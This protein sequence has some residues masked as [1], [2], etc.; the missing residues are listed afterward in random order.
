MSKLKIILTVLLLIA[1]VV[2]P[3]TYGMGLTA[4]ESGQ[5]PQ[6]NLQAGLLSGS[7]TINETD[8][9]PREVLF[10]YHRQTNLQLTPANFQ[11]SPDGRWISWNAPLNG[12]LQ[13]WVAPA[14]DLDRARAVTNDTGQGIGIG[15]HFW[16]Y[17][18][19]TLIYEQDTDGD[20][21]FRWY[22]VDA[23]RAER[24]SL[25]PQKGVRAWLLGMSFDV[26]GE[27]LLG[28]NDRDPRFSDVYRVNISTGERLLVLKNEGFSD[29]TTDN[30]LHIRLAGNTSVDGGTEYYSL[31]NGAWKLFMKVKPEDAMTFP[32]A[33]NRAGDILYLLDSRDRNTAAFA[34]INMTTGEET[35]LS[36]NPK[37]DVEISILHPIDMTP[38]AVSYNYERTHWVALNSSISKDLEYLGTLENGDLEFQCATVDDSKWLVGYNRDTGPRRYYL[39]DRKD[40]KARYLHTDQPELENYTLARMHPIVVKSRDGLDLVCY[41]TL[42]PW[43]D[44]DDDGMPEKPLPMVLLVHGGPWGRDVWGFDAERQFLANR[45]Y[46]VLNVNFRGSGGFGKSFLNAGDREWGGKMQA[47]LLDAVNWTVEKGISDP[48]RIAIM[49]GSYGGYATL[50]GLAMT[51]DF[52]ACGV[53]CYGISNL[54]SHLLTLPPH[55]QSDSEKQIR[56]VG[57][58]RTEEGRQ[59]LRERSPLTYADRIKKPLLI[60]HGAND[61]Q[62]NKNQSDQIVQI[63]VDKGIPIT[64]ALY[65]DEGH[66]FTRLESRLSFYAIVEAFLAQNLGG[67]C[68]PIGHAF[69]GA[70]LTV[71]VGAEKISGLMEI[72]Q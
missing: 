51:P 8:L 20:L 71:P 32:I 42:P 58:Y 25:T 13:I 66:V 6:K 49:G 7:L 69:Q 67:Q 56:R 52:F 46:A 68:E 44:R 4:D 30:D 36:Q 65:A 26:P 29:F 64:Y 39:Y 21:N 16:T 35:I 2:I 60:A 53:D 24:R 15:A 33:F 14:N 9:I 54:T 11:M 70:N 61:P 22:S 5:K 23:L 18:N 40:G 17:T 57:D 38:Q 62:V 63:A 41:C 48:S 3:L 27:I 28:L 50:A 47:D 1:L 10:G 37:A 43:S 59:F 19:N 31:E 45:G 72:L 12:T 34:Q 55:I